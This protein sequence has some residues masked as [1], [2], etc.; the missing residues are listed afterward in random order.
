MTSK[1]GEW[2]PPAIRR[3]IVRFW[4]CPELPQPRRIGYEQNSIKQ[5][6]ARTG[7]GGWATSTP[8]AGMA[9]SDGKRP[10]EPPL[11][12]GIGPSGAGGLA[13]RPFLLR[14]GGLLPGAAFGREGNEVWL[15]AVDRR[16]DPLQRP[17][18][19][20]IARRKLSR[21]QAGWRYEVAAL[22]LPLCPRPRDVTCNGS[23]ER[24]NDKKPALSK[25][26]LRGREGR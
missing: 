23:T 1:F 2:P 8:P 4:T 10:G 3:R 15:P 16:V 14:W 19:K 9:S 6:S 20:A 18:H 24:L 25:A 11:R 12:P 17:P 13:V 5:A 22:L 7:S 26:G 21:M